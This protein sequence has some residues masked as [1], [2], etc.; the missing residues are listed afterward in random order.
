LYSKVFSCAMATSRT[1]L[2]RE[3][4]TGSTYAHI[5][6]PKGSQMGL[7]MVVVLLKPLNETYEPC[8]INSRPARYQQIEGQATLRHLYNQG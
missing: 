7:I 1:P 5:K 4:A 6:G 3:L 8:V 2:K